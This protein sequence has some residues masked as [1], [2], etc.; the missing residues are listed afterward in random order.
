[1]AHRRAV[2]ITVAT[3][4]PREEAKQEVR[5]KQSNARTAPVAG[6]RSPRRQEGGRRDLRVGRD[7]VGA[8]EEHRVTQHKIAGR[9]ARA[10]VDLK[11]TLK[12]AANGVAHLA[13]E[14]EVALARP[15][16]VRMNYV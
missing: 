13:A 1:M 7:A 16:R 14:A 11:R 8:E 12:E 10:E 6:L 2:E 3:P 15:V 4:K 9:R 5:I